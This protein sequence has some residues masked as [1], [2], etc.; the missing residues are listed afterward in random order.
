MTHDQHAM[1][2]MAGGIEEAQVDAV[3]EAA[4]HGVDV[5]AVVA[6]ELAAEADW[7]P[8][9]DHPAA[10]AVEPGLAALE[11]ETEE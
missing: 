3:Q 2:E 1:A 9:P 8:A 5:G 4:A 11:A 10:E 6:A 7:T